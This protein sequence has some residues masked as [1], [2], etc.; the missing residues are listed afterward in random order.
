MCDGHPVCM[1][2]WIYHR[3]LAT[4]PSKEPLVSYLHWTLDP[5]VCCKVNGSKQTAVISASTPRST[6]WFESSVQ[7]A[8]FSY[9]WSKHKEPHTTCEQKVWFSGLQM[10]TLEERSWF[11]PWC[12]PVTP[13][14]AGIAASGSGAGAVA[15][16]I[17]RIFSCQTSYVFV[18]V[19]SPHS[20]DW[21]GAR[22]RCG[23]GHKHRIQD[24]KQGNDL[25][26]LVKGK[27]VYSRIQLC[28]LHSG[29]QNYAVTTDLH[30][31]AFQLCR[32]PACSQQ[33]KG[34]ISSLLASGPCHLIHPRGEKSIQTLKLA[35][36]RCPFWRACVFDR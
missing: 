28:F 36:G 18:G 19:G 8:L 7:I 21:G 22:E 14:A 9:L 1:P 24:I 2:A 17:A 32:Q 20:A 23:G 3:C 33:W 10:G 27:C 30:E 11:S 15:L 6:I 31:S 16:G 26:K 5:S 29:A 34:S 35:G 13:F 4:E 25:W 12:L